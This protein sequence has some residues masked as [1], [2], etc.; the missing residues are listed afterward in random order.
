MLQGGLPNPGM[1]PRPPALQA[2]SLPSEPPGKPKNPGVG[3]LPLPQGIFLTQEL[4]WGLLHCRWSLYQLSYQGS[5]ANI[6]R[7]DKKLKKILRLGIRQ[8]CQFSP[9]LV[10]IVLEVLARSNR[11]E[12]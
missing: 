11:Q 4:T 2:D 12:K 1:E 6:I 3:S 10:N 5:P 8:G 7:D 9:L